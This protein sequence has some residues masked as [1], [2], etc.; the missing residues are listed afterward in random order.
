MN[1]T[2]FS[3]RVIA[4]FLERQRRPY[5]NLLQQ[6]HL[7]LQ[8]TEL[9]IE[10]PDRMMNHALWLRRRHLAKSVPKLGVTALRF[11]QQRGHKR[12]QWP[13][14]KPENVQQEWQ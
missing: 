13:E 9:V 11:R 14:Q 1:Y 7:T 2:S 5:R 3:Q 6:C 12:S 4:L 8:G 10:S